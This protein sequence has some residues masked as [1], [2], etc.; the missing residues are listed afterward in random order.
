[1]KKCIILNA[2]SETRRSL[3]EG[4]GEVSSVWYKTKRMGLHLQGGT[5]T[6]LYKNLPVDWSDSFVFTRLRATDQHFCGILYDYFSLRGIPANDP[7]N[8]SYAYSAEKISQML[9]LSLN[10][11]PI[12]ETFIFR[13]ESF[14]MNRAYFE[15]HI[16]FPCVYKTDG[17]KGRNVHYVTNWAELEALVLKKKPQVLALVQPFIENEFD[18]RTIVVYGE[19]QGSIKRARTHGY[20][21]NIAQGAIPTPYELTSEATRI[22]I[23]S[24]K[25]CGIDLAGVDMIHTPEGPVVIEVNKSP[26]VKGFESVQSFKVFTRAGEIMKK[27]FME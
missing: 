20:L 16:S 12:P 22:A 24:A 25:V 4:L 9:T 27:K 5:A 7:I 15:E 18:T 11:L 8:K 26:Q 19:I 6:F 3:R 2:G 13:E 1:M 17:S 10:G 21:N 23:E 14:K